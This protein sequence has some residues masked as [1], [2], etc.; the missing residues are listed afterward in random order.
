VHLR[1]VGPNSLG[2]VRDAYSLIMNGNG[3]IRDFSIE[4]SNNY[5]EDSASKESSYKMKVLIICV[6]CIIITLIASCILIPVTYSLDSE[7][8]D[9]VKKWLLVSSEAKK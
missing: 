7:Q 2:I 8:E 5:I 3:D 9:I 1:N 6:I 4:V